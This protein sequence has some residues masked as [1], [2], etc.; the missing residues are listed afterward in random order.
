MNKIY[1]VKFYRDDY[2]TIGIYAYCKS[3]SSA[4][5]QKEELLD[6]IQNIKT[7]YYLEYNCDFEKDLENYQNNFFDGLYEEIEDRLTMYFAKH[8]ELNFDDIKIVEKELV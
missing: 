3:Y 7:L 8:P 6:K 4:E 5:K 2:N 1:L